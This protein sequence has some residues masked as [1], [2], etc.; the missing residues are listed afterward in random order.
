MLEVQFG[1]TEMLLLNSA[2]CWSP[3]NVSL[4]PLLIGPL[5]LEVKLN[6]GGAW[7][8][9][10]TNNTGQNCVWRTWHLK[11]KEEAVCERF[12]LILLELKLISSPFRA[13]FCLG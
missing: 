1:S 4:T 13:N 11:Q 3:D 10:I 9:K 12:L 8:S 7:K 6:A 5:K 2:S